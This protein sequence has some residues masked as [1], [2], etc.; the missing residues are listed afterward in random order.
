MQNPNNILGIEYC[1]ALNKLNSKITPFTIKRIGAQHNEKSESEAVPSSSQIR[2]L[3]LAGKNVSPL[4][5]PAAAQILANEIA[6]GNAPANAA[7]LE[8][9]VLSKLRCMSREEFGRLPDISEGLENRIYH[10]VREAVSLDDLYDKIKSKRYTHARIRRLIFSAFLG[11]LKDSIPPAPPYIRVLGFNESGK[12]ILHLAKS[13]TNLPIITNSS[14]IFSLDKHAEN[15]FELE[16][17]STDVFVLSYPHV[18]QCGLEMTT[19]ILTI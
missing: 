12:E 16:C 8:T 17:T 18:R 14:A 2:E 1:K 13:T 5:P 19:G 4:L 7:K 3:I 9:A 15:M 6:C 11:L 10:A